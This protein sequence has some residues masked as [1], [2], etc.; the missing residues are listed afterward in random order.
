MYKIV[1]TLDT[2][3]FLCAGG[4][5]GWGQCI[6]KKGFTDSEYLLVEH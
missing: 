5:G 3:K 1:C 2:Q 4:G 6:W